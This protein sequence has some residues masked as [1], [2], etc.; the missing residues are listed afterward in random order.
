MTKIFNDSTLIL[1]FYQ[2]EILDVLCQ[3][4][5]D[6]SG[7]G[8]PEVGEF[9]ASIDDGICYMLSIEWLRLITSEGDWQN[10]CNFPHSGGKLQMEPKDL[11]YYMQIARNFQRYDNLYGGSFMRELQ[12]LILE[13]NLENCSNFTIDE[14]L[15]P[16]CFGSAPVQ[17]KQ[18][19]AAIKSPTALSH[20]LQTYFSGH[21]QGCL[22]IGI[23]GTDSSNETFGH[24]AAFA[25]YNG[26]IYFFDCN[27]GL[28]EIDITHMDTFVLDLW[29]EYN[30][31][32]A[33]LTGIERS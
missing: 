5:I 7:S 23:Y 29:T 6:E 27:Y 1:D 22:L 2:G 11:A 12:N 24:E 10:F 18:P 26:T 25:V 21:P 17:V 32:K 31:K 15:V 16:L 14:K 28:Y 19:S 9:M 4:L 8:K 13:K 3:S 30:M 20:A 33:E